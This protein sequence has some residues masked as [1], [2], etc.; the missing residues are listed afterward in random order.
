MTIPRSSR[1]TFLGLAA[2]SALGAFG[3]SACGTSGPAQPGGAASG[4]ASAG[5]ATGAATMWAL[6]G[7]PNQGIRQNSV[8]A[9]SK[10]GKGTIKVTFFQNDP[11]KAK[12]RTAVGA[13]QAPT[14]I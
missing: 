14:L 4:S 1:R 5:G 2:G 13:G 6:S 9:F 12:I 11:Y 7:Q 10:L 8:D 3:L